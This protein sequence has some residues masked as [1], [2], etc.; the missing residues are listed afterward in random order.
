MN[1][2]NNNRISFP[3]LLLV[4]GNGRNVGKTWLVCRIIEKISQNQ[5]VTA[6]K[7]SS[8]Y[9]PED[10]DNIISKTNDL[11]F[12]PNQKSIRKTVR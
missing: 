7:I 9:H 3:N 6:V 4:A 10:A 1:N 12:V 8:H 11:L 5:K 2:V